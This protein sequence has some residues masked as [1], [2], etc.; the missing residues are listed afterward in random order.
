MRRRPSP[1]RRCIAFD[2]AVLRTMYVIVFARKGAS[3]HV[4]AR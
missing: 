2:D 3:K 1:R 4:S